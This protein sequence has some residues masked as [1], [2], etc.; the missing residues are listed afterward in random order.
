MERKSWKEFLV[1]ACDVR[2]ISSHLVGNCKLL[3]TNFCFSGDAKFVSATYRLF[4]PKKSEEQNELCVKYK[5]LLKKKI[6]YFR[7]LDLRPFEE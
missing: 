2:Q 4:K 1:R 7:T 5:G 3:K 6:F